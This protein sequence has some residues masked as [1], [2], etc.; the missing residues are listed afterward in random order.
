[1]LHSK[2][3]PLAN[4][5]EPLKPADSH[6]DSA[7]S[8]VASHEGVLVEAV[9]EALEQAEATMTRATAMA[10]IRMAVTVRSGV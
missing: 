3:S 4:A 10:V 8:V 9:P 7:A 2:E 1:M 6:S 5:T